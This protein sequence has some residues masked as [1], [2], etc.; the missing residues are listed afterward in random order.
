MMKRRI[1]LIYW[2]CAFVFLP[3][4]AHAYID[5]ATTTYLI[6][7][8]TAVVVMAGVSL[9][10]FLY[11][12]RMISSKIK[13][14]FFRLFYRSKI[15]KKGIDA[16]D[17]SNIQQ[18]KT[19][20]IPQYIRP[21]S[22]SPPELL[23]FKTES[24]EALFES[25]SDEDLE[26]D[27]SKKIVLTSYQLRIRFV[28]PLV[29]AFSF[30]FIII[31]C[32]ELA[33]RHSPEIPFTIS[34]IV[35]VVLLLF[36]VVFV[37]LIL[38]IPLFRGVIF[39]V[40]CSIGLSIL[41]AG[42]LQG[43]FLN[44]GLGQL[45]GDSVNW[46]ELGLQTVVSLICWAACFIV[47]F[48]LHRRSK[49]TWRFL[50]FFVP[51]LL[52]VIQ[53]AS[54]ISVISKD[55]ENNEWG[56]G[57]YWRHA[58]EALT[59]GR[60]NEVASEQNAIIFVL[61]RLDDNYIEEILVEDP[62]FFAPLDGFTRFNDFVTHFG[63]TF[64]SVTSILTG[65]RYMF[66][67]PRVQFFEYA[68]E[69]A[70]FLWTLEEHGFDIRLYMDRGDSFSNTSQLRGLASNIVTS[71]I[72][73]K[74][75]TALVKL[76]RLSGYR[77][78]PMPLKQF[79]WFSPT[80]FVDTLA[81]NDDNAPYIVND[82]AYYER[83][84]DNGLI[85]S[86]NQNSFKYIHLLGPHSPYYMDENIQFTGDSTAVQ[87]AMGAFRIVFEYLRQL[88][89][90]GLYDDA[91]IIIMGDHGAYDK[92][93]LNRDIRTGLFVKPAGSSGTP[94][95]LSHAPVSPDQLHATIME[96][97]FGDTEGFGDTFFNINEGDEIIRQ[98]TTG[99]YR[100]EIFGDGRDFANWNQI[101]R[102]PDTYEK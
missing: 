61:D 36:A 1:V 44:I 2:I 14:G 59:I 40:F 9:S 92:L 83:L 96:S 94:M 20:V 87:Q 62:D 52:I 54:L 73:V 22:D 49:K 25:K 47:V 27:K 72:E 46:S 60:I 63:S 53:S 66:D 48:L 12:F 26:R 50:L 51:I 17:G 68:W 21:G 76:L 11:R 28:V 67:Q 95:R 32:L 8:A 89:E 99:R 35:P 19:T 77:F 41:I 29:L 101:G 93:E 55:M 4:A 23:T 33:I 98:Y 7:I 37:A 57:V 45:T 38:I 100:Y 71:E 88:R 85:I 91:V 64:P 78:A 43:N 16:E 97:L 81:L 74:E 70:D 6:Q 56:E 69:N 24:R 15:D 31:G 13:Y 90:L 58:E 86:E 3:K 80:E 5:P 102:F 75:R 82:I 42:Y 34:S 79:F 18:P 10:V 65:H 84:R 39:E 30:T